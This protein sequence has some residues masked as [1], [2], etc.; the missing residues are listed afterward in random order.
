MDAN[1]PD[2]LDC[3]RVGP[4]EIDK[5][6]IDAARAQIVEQRSR[7]CMDVYPAD[8]ERDQGSPQR[9]REKPC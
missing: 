1:R 9:T 5:G 4:C 7:V 6:G 2:R 3:G 8:A